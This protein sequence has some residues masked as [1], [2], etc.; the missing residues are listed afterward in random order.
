MGSLQLESHHQV[1]C[2][3]ISRSFVPLL[4]QGFYSSGEDTVGVF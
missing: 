3:V 1:Q 4:G 2:S